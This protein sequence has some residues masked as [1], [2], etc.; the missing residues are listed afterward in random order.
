MS[1]RFFIDR[2]IFAT[3]IALVMT[4]SGIIC[5]YL[6]PIAQFP[7]IVPPTVQVSATYNGADANTVAQVVTLPLEQQI[8]GVEGMLYMSSTSTSAGVSTITVTFEVGYDLDIAAVDVLTRVN[9]AM[10]QLP[11]AVQ[12][13]GVNI[14]K[15]STNMTGVV[16]LYSPKGTY[17]SAF[18]S[19]YANIT[20]E[21]VLS[22]VDGVG[23][24]TV[25]GL[26]QYAMRIWLDPNKLT[27]LGLTGDDVMNAVRAQNL[28]ASLGAIGAE[29]SVERPATM[30]A[31][32]AVGR[33]VKVEDFADIVVR[34][35]ENGAIVRLRDIGEVD[36]G[37]YQYS[38]T[39][40]LNGG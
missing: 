23:N 5:A 30:L 18:L 7:N 38:S 32:Q 3:V 35:G 6:L 21:P 36:L 29:P 25:F 22:R 40:S 20:V 24:T 2:P 37:S 13:V 4:L 17:D 39:S 31:I 28:Q 12:R 10:P 16:S 15:Q 19:N 9:Q 33:L 1:F 26:E 11:E 34:A 27:Q 14:A 8:N